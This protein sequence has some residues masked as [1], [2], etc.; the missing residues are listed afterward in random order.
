[1]C[2]GGCDSLQVVLDEEVTTKAAVEEI[3]SPSLSLLELCG[4]VGSSRGD[5]DQFPCR[6]TNSAVFLMPT[7]YIE[8]VSEDK[9]HCIFFLLHKSAAD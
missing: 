5:E 6:A 8:E 9:D 3:F 2:V 7:Y 1:M 4:Q